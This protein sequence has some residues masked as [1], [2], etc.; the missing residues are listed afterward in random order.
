MFIKKRYIDVYADPAH[1][2][3]IPASIYIHNKN[4]LK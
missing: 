4:A 1:M 2:K 3:S